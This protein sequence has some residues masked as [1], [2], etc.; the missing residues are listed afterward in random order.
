MAEYELHSRQP[1]GHEGGES[2]RHGAVFVELVGQYEGVFHRHAGALGQ[3]RRDGV[4][5]VA[6]QDDMAVVPGG[7]QHTSCRGAQ[8]ISL[9]SLMESLM[10]SRISPMSPPKP[11]RR[12][13]SCSGHAAPI[14]CRARLGA[15]DDQQVHQVL[16][17]VDD[18]C[19]DR[20]PVPV[21]AV[22]EPGGRGTAI[23]QHA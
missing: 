19:L 1:P 12:S 4:R 20:G 9:D 8:W 16:I 22:G 17:Q 10:E 13:R 21:L 23:R 3:V 6:G 18:R 14:W 5:G 7:G 11:V 2:L 15:L